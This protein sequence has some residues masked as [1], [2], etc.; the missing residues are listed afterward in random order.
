MLSRVKQIESAADIALSWVNTSRCLNAISQSY[1]FKIGNKQLFICQMKP[2]KCILLVS[3][4]KYMT[5]LG[6][7]HMK[8]VRFLSKLTNSHTRYGANCLIN[9]IQR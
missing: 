4:D 9:F 8:P 5:V 2:T 3:F 6:M 1:A 7:E